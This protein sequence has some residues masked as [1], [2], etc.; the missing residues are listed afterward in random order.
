MQ[1]L[2]V[3]ICTYNRE[4][5]LNKCLNE[6]LPQLGVNKNVRVLVVDN[7]ST[8]NTAELVQK[9]R[10]E[11]PSLD[12]AFCAEQGLSYARNYALTHC[13]SKWL[14]FLDDDGYPEQNWLVQNLELINKGK[15]DAFGGVYLP[16][17][18]DGKK[19]WFKDNYESNLF[20][21]PQHEETR[22]YPKDSYF[23]GG[24]CCF[25]VK[26]L[27]DSGGFPVTLGMNGKSMGY[28]EELAAQRAMAINGYTLGYSRNMVIHHCVPFSKQSIR[29]AWRREYSKGKCFWLVYSKSPTLKNIIFYSKIRFK[30]SIRIS[31]S[32]ILNFSS[33]RM[34]LVRNVFYEMSVWAG[35]LGLLVGVFKLKFANSFYK[36]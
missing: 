2:T 3:A 6:L 28:G 35:L 22:L 29:W 26:A 13:Q 25:K 12:Y 32:L 8:D 5:F 10:R 19:N 14:S 30:K 31:K 20:R 24:N 9:F 23:S 1:L 11:Y 15:Y 34:L 33:D 4:N 17:F 7:G 16:W 21:M 18:K 27:S 36:K